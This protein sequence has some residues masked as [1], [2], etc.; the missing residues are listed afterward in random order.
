MSYTTYS[1]VVLAVLTTTIVLAVLTATVCV[2]TQPH[3]KTYAA[4]CWADE[5]L[6]CQPACS[7]AWNSHTIKG[8]PARDTVAGLALLRFSGSNMAFMAGVMRMRSP[9][10]S[11]STLLSSSTAW[12]AA[13]AEA[14]RRVLSW[15]NRSMVSAWHSVLAAWSAGRIA[16]GC[17]RLVLVPIAGRVAAVSGLSR[18]SVLLFGG[19]STHPC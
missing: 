19:R 18:D 12:C 9:L 15:G 6:Q 3:T 8:P 2:S 14:A 1:L 17:T 10:A 13:G 4:V 7:N 5:G 16:A 11:V